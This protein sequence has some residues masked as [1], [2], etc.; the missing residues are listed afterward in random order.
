MLVVIHKTFNRFLFIFSTPFLSKD[1]NKK[2]L[3]ERYI[4]GTPRG[5]FLNS[6]RV[7]GYARIVYD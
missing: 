3:K 2:V 4:A 6:A 5:I 1:K 7:I